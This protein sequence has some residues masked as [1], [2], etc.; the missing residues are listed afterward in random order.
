MNQNVRHSPVQ[1]NRLNLVTSIRSFNPFSSFHTD[2]C[3]LFLPQLQLFLS[4]LHSLASA[5]SFQYTSPTRRTHVPRPTPVS[6]LTLVTLLIYCPLLVQYKQTASA[7]YAKNEQGRRTEGQ[8]QLDSSDG[9][10]LRDG[11]ATQAKAEL[12][13]THREQ[14]DSIETSAT[15]LSR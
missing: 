12:E 5:S 14:R 11:R 10:T 8:H 2:I 9:C 15:E 7:R 6:S 1:S 4:S 3:R 13:S